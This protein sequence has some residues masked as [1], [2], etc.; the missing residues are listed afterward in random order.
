MYR[1]GVKRRTLDF[2]GGRFSMEIGFEENIVKIV[3]RELGIKETQP[4]LEWSNINNQPWAIDSSFT[5]SHTYGVVVKIKPE[6]VLDP[7]KIGG[8][9]SSDQK[10]HSKLLGDL[11]CVQCRAVALEW[12]RSLGQ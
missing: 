4:I 10:G 8:M 3:R 7:A 11:M 5:N 6:I 1:P 2:C 9:Y 12:L